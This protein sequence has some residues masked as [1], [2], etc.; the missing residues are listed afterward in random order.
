MK[1]FSIFAPN[2]LISCMNIKIIRNL[3][4][5]LEKPLITRNLHWK[6]LVR[7][8]FVKNSSALPFHLWCSHYWNWARNLIINWNVVFVDWA[9][10]GRPCFRDND[11]SYNDALTLI[12]SAPL[13]SAVFSLVKTASPAFSTLSINM[14][15]TRT[16]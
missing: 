7:K 4:L 6:T 11:C 16:N 14:S 9:R 13:C 5:Y 10:W 15:W 1:I 2:S 8:S 3:L 12:Q